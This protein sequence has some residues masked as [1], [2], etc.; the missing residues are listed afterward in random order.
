M[1]EEGIELHNLGFPRMMFETFESN[2]LFV[3]RYMID[4]GVVAAAGCRR[5]RAGTSLAAK[6][7][8]PSCQHASWTCT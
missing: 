6:A 3:L 4:A 8:D 7:A 1:V 5:R 2:V